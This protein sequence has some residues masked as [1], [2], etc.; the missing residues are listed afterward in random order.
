[1]ALA[2]E[3]ALAAARSATEAERARRALVSL[4]DDDPGLESLPELA[5]ARRNLRGTLTRTLAHEV[6]ETGRHAAALERLAA[7]VRAGRLQLGG[8]EAPDEA[9]AHAEAFAAVLREAA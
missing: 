6:G 5:E 1:M 2:R 8:P 3:L 4:D 7:A 9:R